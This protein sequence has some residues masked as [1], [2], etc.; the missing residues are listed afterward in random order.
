MEF[1]VETGSRLLEQ[2]SIRLSW[3][4]KL[5]HSRASRKQL[6]NTFFWLVRRRLSISNSRQAN[7]Q[8][9]LL[10]E[11]QAGLKADLD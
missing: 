9:V 6:K 5:G 7:D 11:S 2:K 10:L 1:L 4:G 3:F 8:P